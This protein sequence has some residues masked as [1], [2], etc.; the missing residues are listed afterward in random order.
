MVTSILDGLLPR[1][2]TPIHKNVDEPTIKYSD[3]K[4]V[5]VA[6]IRAVKLPGGQLLARALDRKA[7]KRVWVPFGRSE[8]V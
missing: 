2:E 5:R 4:R 8:V 1:S 3:I 6:G 7:G